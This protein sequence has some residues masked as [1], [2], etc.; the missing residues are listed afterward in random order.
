MTKVIIDK[1]FSGSIKAENCTFEYK[2]IQCTGALFTIEFQ[3]K[4]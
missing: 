2:G 4:K 1:S 3:A